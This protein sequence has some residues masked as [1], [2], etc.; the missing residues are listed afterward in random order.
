MSTEGKKMA[1][2]VKKVFEIQGT[3]NLSLE[4]VFPADKDGDYVP[5]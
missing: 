2:R 1:Y 4:C 3:L 5:G